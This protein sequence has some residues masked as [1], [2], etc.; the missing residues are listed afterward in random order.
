LAT[1]ELPNTVLSV[2]G[3]RKRAGPIL[4]VDDYDDARAIVCEAL[5]EAGHVVI[6][7]AN[8]QQALNVLV[9]PDQNVSLIIVDLQMPVMDGWRFIEL[10]NCYVKLSTIPVIV[11]TAAS[12]PHLERIK[13][14]AVHGC[15]QAPYDLRTLLEMVDSCLYPVAQQ[16]AANTA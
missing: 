14:P 12:E 8:G 15:L 7:A 3:T 2:S 11:A 16:G 4:L 10:L 1:R 13:H 6:E 5:E 9:A